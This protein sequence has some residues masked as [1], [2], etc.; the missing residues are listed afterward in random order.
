MS[1]PTRLAAFGYHDV[2]DDPTS[3]GFQRPGAVPYRLTRDAFARHLEA[4]ARGQR[5]PIRVTD[6]ALGEPGRHVLLTFDDGG[7]SA[8]YTG[9]RLAE[10]GWRGHFFIV[11]S[12]LG[13]RTFLAPADVRALFRQ[14]HVIGSHSHTHPGIFREQPYP[15]MLEEWRV[16]CDRLAQIT[17]QP[18][19]TASVPGG[20]ISPEALRSADEAGLRSL[21]TSEPWTTPRRVGDCWVVGRFVAKVSTT[22]AQIAD[23]A[24][25]RGWGRVLLIRRL[26]NATRFAAPSLYRMLVR[27]RTEP[28]S[29]TAP[30]SE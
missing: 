16:S 27:R 15:R 2:A 17:G 5:A 29:L 25:F 3:S 28:Q 14:G 26:K 18:C 24:R 30:E 13:S 22:P 12:L 11:T 23:L 21:F 7:A 9:E 20:D 4:F 1:V 19:V 8:L 6:V 10:R